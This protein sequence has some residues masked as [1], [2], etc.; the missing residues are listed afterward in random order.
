MGGSSAKA[1]SEF[2][3]TIG[4]ERLANRAID[5]R[6]E[7]TA[8]ERD[9]VKERL[10]LLALDQFVADCRVSQE[11]GGLVR[12]DCDWRADLAQAC[13]VTLE[14][15]EQSLSGRFQA[16]YQAQEGAAVPEAEIMVDP[17]A[18]D[19]PEPLPS[20]GI[21]LGELAVQELAVALDPYPRMAGAEIPSRYQPPE[22]EGVA[23]PFDAL[24]VLKSKE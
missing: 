15:I 11:L 21:D 14:P 7:A 12:V 19:P 23:N 2:S 6:I 24:K 9:L 1:P 20:A 22:D 13:V 4:L 10:G 16:L 3:R 17:E 18:E 5:E 8:G